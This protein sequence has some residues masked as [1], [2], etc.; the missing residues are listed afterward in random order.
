MENFFINCNFSSF[1]QSVCIAGETDCLYKI[2]LGPHAHEETI[3]WIKH[4]YPCSE[5]IDSTTYGNNFFLILEQFMNKKTKSVSY[6][7]H[8]SATDF[9]QKVLKEVAA[10]PYGNTASYSEIAAKIGQP[11]AFRA[12]GNACNINPLPLLIPCHRVVAKN[13]IG[14]YAPGISYK[15]M[16]LSL[17]ESVN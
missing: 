7:Y 11:R 3:A 4:Y 16:L 14:G 13:H 5:I 12:V 9:Q 10:I 15:K 1:F 6:P 2:S 17:E 8:L